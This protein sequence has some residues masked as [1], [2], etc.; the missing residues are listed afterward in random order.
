MVF[1]SF[2]FIDLD[3]RIYVYE[4]LLV[5][6]KVKKPVIVVLPSE[7]EYVLSIK[8]DFEKL[9]RLITL[10]DFEKARRLFAKIKKIW[11]GL[12]Y[13]L[14]FMLRKEVYNIL[15]RFEEIKRKKW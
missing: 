11:S 4:V 8:K 9:D 10:K 12:P 15:R 6:R 7:E 2:S 13:R 3:W 5:R 14:K 1:L